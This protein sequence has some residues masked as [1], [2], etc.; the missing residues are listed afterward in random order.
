[1]PTRKKTSAMPVKLTGPS[2]SNFSAH[3]TSQSVVSDAIS[4][5]FAGGVQT[6]ASASFET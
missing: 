3:E 2:L 1:M 4:L 5:H 6:T